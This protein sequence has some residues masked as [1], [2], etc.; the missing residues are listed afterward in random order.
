[1]ADYNSQLT[2]LTEPIQF[3]FIGD[4]HTIAY[5]N[6]LYSPDNYT[7]KPIIT[8]GAYLGGIQASNIFKA[9]GVI[10]DDIINA[11]RLFGL[12]SKYGDILHLSRTSAANDINVAA[13]SSRKTPILT[14]C[15]GEI[16]VRSRLLKQIGDNVDFQIPAISNDSW[17]S[18][19]DSSRIISIQII[20]KL[21]RDTY[22]P[23][24]VALGGLIKGGFHRIYLHSIAPPTLNDEKF[25]ELNGYTFSRLVHYKTVYLVNEYLESQCPL[26]NIRFINTWDKVTERDELL[27]EFVLDHIHLN[28]KACAFAIREIIK[29]IYFN[30]DPK[31][32]ALRYQELTTESIKS[33]QKELN[34]DETSLS[35][36]ESFN[37]TSLYYSSKIFEPED[38]SSMAN[39]LDFSLVEENLAPLYDWIG[40]RGKSNDVYN[41]TCNL[42]K[43]QLYSIYKLIYSKKCV[44]IIESCMGSRFITLVKGRKSFPHQDKGLGSQSPHRDGNPPGIKRGILYLSDVDQNSGPFSIILDTSTGKEISICGPK[45]TFI[46]FDA[47]KYY[48]RGLPPR[49]KIRCALDFVFIPCKSDTER[50]I[51]H[52]TLNHWPVDPYSFDITPFTT[53][54]VIDSETISLR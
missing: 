22:K 25:A 43:E 19:T 17:L 20:R 16:D 18:N 5:N 32:L 35:M 4:S 31:A 3:F 12:I 23:L 1:M 48:H 39:R 9:K 28:K 30:A 52:P 14:F 6:I 33:Y 7:K 15:I 27:E 38:I 29:D 37:Q 11:L 2:E 46:L 49:K 26:Y 21:I 34:K 42:S 41:K 36:F 50:F 44:K 40:G 10:R 24:L 45:G 53:W 47:Q 13:Q 51:L 8:R 54:P